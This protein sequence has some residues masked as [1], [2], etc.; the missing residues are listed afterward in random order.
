[1]GH[2]LLCGQEDHQAVAQALAPVFA[3]DEHEAVLLVGHGTDHCAWTVYPAF[4]HRLRRIYGNRAFG[5]M[6]EEGWPS[7]EG[8]IDHIAA[9][10]FRR[11]RLMPFM[12]VAGVHFEEDL[13]GQDDSWKSGLESRGLEVILETE[14]LGPRSTVIDIF[15]EHIKSALAVIPASKERV[16]PES[17]SECNH[18]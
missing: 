9:T 5:G 15:T 12:L 8:V 13:A 7:R 4:Y 10:G 17:I 14:A 3:K 1:V 18:P 2:S 16:E 11:V 6:I